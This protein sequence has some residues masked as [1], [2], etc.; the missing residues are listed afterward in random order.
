LEAALRPLLGPARALDGLDLPSRW[1]PSAATQRARAASLP[2]PGEA[3]AALREAMQGLPFRAGAF[4]P[5]LAGLAASRDLPVLTAARLGAEAP[6]LAA[7]LSPL[8]SGEGNAVRGIGLA[9]GVRDPAALARAVAGLGDPHVLLV[10][11]KAETEGLLAAYARAT[12]LWALAGGGAVLLL[13]GLG[14]GGLLLALRVAAPIGGALLVTLAALA[15]LGEG[16]TL[17]QLASLLLLA[18]LA[19]D[20]ALFL[21]RAAGPGGEAAA[22][23]TS[24]GAVLNCA[25]AT[26]LTFGMLSFCETPVL[27]G[28]GVTVSVGVAS[29][30]LLALAM[31]PARISGRAD[32]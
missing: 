3:E 18:G 30:F 8:L 6:V 4:D 29:A 1:L 11:I 2:A 9:Q 5:F 24:S 17:F 12:L 23:E 19:I 15:A 27:R 21:A 22:D 25:V 26:L 32:G 31:A 7:R 10:D 20:Y 28:I 14:L 13:L 16:L